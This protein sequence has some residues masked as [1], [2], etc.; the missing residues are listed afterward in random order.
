M[1]DK[2]VAVI[3]GKEEV[4]DEATAAAALIADKE[5]VGDEATASATVNGPDKGTRRKV[6]VM[7]SVVHEVKA[8]AARGILR[9]HKA[10]S[11]SPRRRS[12]RSSPGRRSLTPAIPFATTGA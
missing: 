6:R 2:D 9:C 1:A 8:A 11:V 4:G 12:T 5:E 3:A 10:R 7:V